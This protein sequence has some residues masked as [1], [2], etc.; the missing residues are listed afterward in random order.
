[1]ITEK[2]MQAQ[3]ELELDMHGSGVS[4]FYR[5]NN[6]AI[7]SGNHSET[8]W[9]RRIITQ[10]IDP[11]TK[12]IQAYHEHYAHKRGTKP[13]ALE[14]IKEAQPER[15]AYITIKC[16]LDAVG[17]VKTDAHSL[18]MKIGSR[19]EDQIRFTNL[20]ESA[21]KYIERIKESLAKRS[22]ADYAHQHKVMVATERKLVEEAER[23]AE[24][25]RWVSWR[26]EDCKHVGAALVNI[27]T[28]SVLFEGHPVIEMKTFTVARKRM[29]TRI[30]AAD[31]MVQW[32]EKYKEAV[33]GM[34]PAYGPCVVPPRDWTSPFTGGF[35][36]DELSSS[37]ALVKQRNKSHLR[38]LTPR[39]MPRVYKAVNFMQRVG[40]QV[41][42]RVLATANELVSLGLPFALPS[43]DAEDWKSKH[44]CPVPEHLSELKG[45]ALKSA[46]STKQWEEFKEWKSLCREKYDAEAERVASYHEVVRT[47]GQ[48]N[49]YVKY[50]AFYFVYNL[51]FRGRV[52]VQSSLLSPQGGDLQKG[53]IKF[54]KGMALG[55]AGE[56]WFKVQGA[57]VWGW[58]KKSMDERVEL[59][60][61]GEFVQMCLDIADD[62]VTF[63]EWIN[64]DKPW[65][66]LNWCFEY[67]DLIKHKQA[68]NPAATYVSYIPVAMDGSCSGIQHY[69]MMLRDEVGGAAVNLL[70]S[71]K[72]NDIYRTVLEV[73]MDKVQGLSDGTI[74]YSGKLDQRMMKEIA[75]EWLRLSP[76]R[77]LTKKSV[78][79]LPYGSTQMTC[80][81][82]VTSW[83]RDLQK[84]ENKLAK[85]E[86]REPS[87][88]HFFG[89]VD[90]SMPLKE[91]ISF[92][93]SIIWE[94]IGNVVIAA[95]AA[96]KYIKAV[97]GTVAKMNKPLLFPAPTGFLVLQEVYESKATRV[98]T[99]LM[100]STRFSMLEPTKTIDYHRMLNSSAPNFV[101]AHD[102]AH[103]T[104]A[105]NKMEDAG[106]ASLALIHDSF[107]TH[108]CNTPKLN[109]LLREAAVE[110]YEEH[111][112]IRDF[113]EA[114][115]ER[116]V[117]GF[118]HIQIPARGN[119]DLNKIKE[120]LYAFA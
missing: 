70:P 47:L 45:E 53:L 68:G 92:M 72:P 101:H 13:I 6:R 43:K 73:A 44:P 58:D 80:R 25:S 5:N 35:Y 105:T 103:L 4:R 29:V 23:E 38:K 113:I 27:F 32:I 115:E 1:M 7:E 28:N 55:E 71:D 11:M 10:L 99:Q 40:W 110:M 50:D 118:D 17:D 78:M 66:F 94:S 64:A 85:A 90:S 107:G 111:D 112:V 77:S 86:R 79:T 24:L 42:E 119:L 97:T 76:S 30:V 84:E 54:S 95:R 61:S 88:A 8:D 102:A 56:Y 48:A 69:S 37:M 26:E 108:A 21:P 49:Q 87:K 109:E 59:A 51:D 67:A 34:A 9:S 104:W 114:Q 22:S 14:K 96:M 120:S 57:N 60:S 39:Q 3:I 36:T 65:Q 116:L 82:H 91:A 2:L 16:I 81:E 18:I 62:P 46:L 33:G 117:M 12:G 15:A 100:G 83:L 75:G 89:G 52:Y 41:S 74:D 31:N 20:E 63:N 98:R 106:L 19:I 93:S